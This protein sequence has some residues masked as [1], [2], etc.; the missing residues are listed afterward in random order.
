VA[1]VIGLQV[2]SVERGRQTGVRGMVPITAAWWDLYRD[3]SVHPP[4]PTV[5]RRFGSWT[6]ACERAGVPTRAFA[7]PPGRTKTW[8]D[9]EILAAVR[10]FLTGPPRAQTSFSAYD[11]W[12]RL[13]Q[14]RPSGATVLLRFGRWGTARDR[15]LA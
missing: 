5:V 13:R 2:K 14:A 9:E 12:S 10:E 8:S 15:A 6:K 1:I 4:S 3:R 7:A 11:A